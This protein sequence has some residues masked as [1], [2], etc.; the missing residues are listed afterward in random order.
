MSKQW[1]T[2]LFTFLAFS[3][4][5][6][7]NSLHGTADAAVRCSW[8]SEHFVRLDGKPRCESAARC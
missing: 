3:F 4:L 5:F 7:G 1:M 6:L 2:V 8:L